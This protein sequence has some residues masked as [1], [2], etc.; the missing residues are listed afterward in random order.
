ME[1]TASLEKKQILFKEIHHRVKNNL[2]VIV[3]LLRLQEDQIDSVESARDAFE[4][5]RN[6]IYSMAPVRQDI[7]QAVP[8]GIIINEL[9]TNAQNHAFAGLPGSTIT[10]SVKV[11]AGNVRREESGS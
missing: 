5:S 2:N 10:V 11:R 3:S 1:L 8:C 9:V 4:Q 7:T 6:R